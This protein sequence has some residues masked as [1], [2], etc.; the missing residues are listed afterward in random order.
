[1][2]SEPN[3]KSHDDTVGTSAVNSMIIVGPWLFFDLTE[4]FGRIPVGSRKLNQ[5]GSTPKQ[6]LNFSTVRITGIYL[7]HLGQ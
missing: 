3:S 6:Y 2:N 5:P 4:R 7:G 1:M